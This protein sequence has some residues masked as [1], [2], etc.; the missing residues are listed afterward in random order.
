MERLRQIGEG[1]LIDAFGS[2][3]DDVKIF[4]MPA[5]GSLASGERLKM[6]WKAGRGGG[7]KGDRDE[8]TTTRDAGNNRR[9]KLNRRISVAPMMDWTD[10]L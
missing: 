6:Q 10:G 7:V 4:A 3:V 2:V 8:E 1:D 9:M 5:L